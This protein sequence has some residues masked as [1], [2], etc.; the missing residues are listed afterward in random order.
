[1]WGKASLRLS[2]DNANGMGWDGEPNTRG[3]EPGG[4]WRGGMEGFWWILQGICPAGRDCLL[5]GNRAHT[6][7]V[8]REGF[9]R[10]L[11]ILCWGIPF[12][13]SGH[14]SAKGKRVGMFSASQKARSWA[15]PI[16]TDGVMSS[17]SL[18]PIRIP[19]LH[20]A[21]WLGP[22]IDARNR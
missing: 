21:N 12:G 5:A 9:L 8:K 15:G 14:G 11:T 7:E 4:G 22:W 17:H 13:L 3:L 10:M 6:G 18:N 20:P 16:R 2:T 19:F 1:M